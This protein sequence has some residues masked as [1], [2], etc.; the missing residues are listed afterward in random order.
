MMKKNTKSGQ[1]VTQANFVREV[2][3][4]TLAFFNDYFVAMPDVL[5]S[6]PFTGKEPQLLLKSFIQDGCSDACL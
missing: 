6:C 4:G 2:C 5:F 1:T 3:V